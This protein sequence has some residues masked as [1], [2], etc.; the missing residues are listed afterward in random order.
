NLLAE[1]DNPVLL[2]A[3]TP[4]RAAKF[5]KERRAAGQQ[6][7]DLIEVTNDIEKV[8]KS[9]SVIFPIIPSANFRDMMK[10][11]S[12]FLKPYHILIHG[13]KGLDLAAVQND[14]IESKNPLTREHVK[15]MSEVIQEESQVVRVGCLA[16][17]NLA[18]EISE[19]KPA[20]TVVASHFDEVI[21]MGEQLLKNDRFL[22]YGSNDLIGIELC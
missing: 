18:R 8:T 2:F 5:Q 17:P 10:Q 1:K 12:P 9:C 22:I 3:R 21:K 15:T 20:A 14:R 6:L 16:G 4:E 19:R 7:D 11:M 13:T